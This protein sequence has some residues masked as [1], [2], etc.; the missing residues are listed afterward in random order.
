MPFTAGEA[1]S[2]T[3]PHEIA[4]EWYG[5]EEIHRALQQAGTDSFGACEAIPPDIKSEKFSR[6]LTHQYRLAMAKGIV[7]GRNPEEKP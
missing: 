1:M 7:I 4:K 3:T 6:W 5:F 2:L